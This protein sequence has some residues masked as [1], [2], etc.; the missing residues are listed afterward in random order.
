MKYQLS[1]LAEMSYN[2]LLFALDSNDARW[3]ELIPFLKDWCPDFDGWIASNGLERTPENAMEYICVQYEKHFSE[4]DRIAMDKSFKSAHEAS[5]MVG[6]HALLD[7]RFRD[8]E[9]KPYKGELK[10]GHFVGVKEEKDVNPMEIKNHR[11]GEIRKVNKTTDGRI[12]SFILNNEVG[13]SFAVPFE[14]TYRIY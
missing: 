6:F 3:L 8:F 4:R 5:R 14:N 7:K 9:N 1:E 12:I 10:I 11:I 2:N 13:E